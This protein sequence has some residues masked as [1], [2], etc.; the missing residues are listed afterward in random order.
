MLTGYFSGS[1]DFGGG[2][3]TSA[4][5][6]DI[7]L[8]KYDASGNHLW[9]KRFGGDLSDYGT[10][11]ALDASGKVVATGACQNA[12]DL[13]GGPLGIKGGTDIFLAKYGL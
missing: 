1:A 13:G 10:A 7:F 9:S 5:S 11:A 8:A 4:G 2:T 3:L 6:D 12:I